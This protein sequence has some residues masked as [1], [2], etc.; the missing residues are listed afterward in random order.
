MVIVILWTINN[1]ND[2]NLWNSERKNT[3]IDL[4]VSK[5]YSFYIPTLWII[6]YMLYT[7]YVC[8]G[9]ANAIS[10]LNNFTYHFM[11]YCYYYYC[12]LCCYYY[13]YGLLLLLLRKIFFL[14][15]NMSMVNLDE[16]NKWQAVIKI[17]L[18]TNND[19]NKAL[20]NL[21]CMALRVPP[22]F[23]VLEKCIIL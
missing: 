21:S 11:V 6:I 8:K 5:V 14:C 1:N 13:Y 22:S 2:N 4:F 23:T 18:W 19:N 15:T 20:K 16:N 7:N 17:I 9:Y 3:F 10:L 12:L